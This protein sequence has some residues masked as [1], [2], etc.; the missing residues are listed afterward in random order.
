MIPRIGSALIGGPLAGGFRAVQGGIGRPS[1][2]V[3]F[4]SVLQRH[5][6]DLRSIPP[7]RT[8][9]RAPILPARPPSLPPPVHDD[10]VLDPLHRRRAAFGPPEGCALFPPALAHLPP[11]SPTNAVGTPSA[12]ALT[13]EQLIPAL[14][15][16]VAW[17]G[18]RHRGSVHLELGAGE[19]VGT[20]LIVHAEAGTVRVNMVTPNGV[21]TAL[22]QERI[23]RRLALRGIPTESVEVT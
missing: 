21:D 9:E 19:L 14:V 12:A 11:A 8:A 10:D 5:S 18:D 20:T 16:R 3:S 4:R 2:R 22:W 23:S 17:A 15:R 13:L 1:P 7:R 6:V